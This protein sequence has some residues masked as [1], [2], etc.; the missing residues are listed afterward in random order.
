MPHGKPTAPAAPARK[1]SQAAQDFTAAP[2]A[3]I[4]LNHRV[5]LGFHGNWVSA[6]DLDA[7]IKQS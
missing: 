6:A 4:K 3:R 5:P 1:W 2:V 7:A